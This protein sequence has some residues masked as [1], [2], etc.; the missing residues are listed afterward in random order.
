MFDSIGRDLDE[1]AT[2][3]QAKAGA[4]ALAISAFIGGLTVVAGM[5]VIR[6]VVV[7]QLQED[8]VEIAM[9]DEVD[10]AAPPPPPPPPPPPAAADASE[11]TEE[12]EPTPDDMTE[13]VEELK[14]EV[15]QEM[16][17]DVKPAGVEGGVE[18][19]VVGGVVG[20]VQGGVVGGVI[21]G[22]LGGQPAKVIHHSEIQWKRKIE[23]VYPVAARG[24]GLGEQKCKVTLSIDEAGVPY[25][26]K[27]DGCPKVFHESTSE[28]LL[29]W[30]AYPFKVNG[31]SIRVQSTI[32]VNY[33]EVG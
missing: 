4:I 10:M 12:T 33:R 11:E 27:I 5:W 29:K 2:R 24:L 31:Q 32:L 9:E 14:E 25:D 23:P 22:Q 8:I 15:K 30:R 18:G 1:E 17:S 28:G 6:E 20:G 13:E 16:K 21:G 3:R 7:D 19:G 26:I